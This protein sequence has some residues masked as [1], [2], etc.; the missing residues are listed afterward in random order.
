MV[1]LF[2]I[3]KEVAHIS[4][5]CY[6]NYLLKDI[7]DKYGKTIAVKIF[8][9]FHFMCDL[10]S[11]NPYS[12]ISESE[13]LEFIIRNICPELPLEV[14][15]D[16]EMITEALDS[17]RKIY[18]T[19]SYRAYLATKSLIDKY[20]DKINAVEISLEKDDGNS[21]EVK[22]AIEILESIKQIAKKQF[23]DLEEENGKQ[24]A[25]GGGEFSYDD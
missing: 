18:E 9:V 4:E 22:K 16:D 13:K 12:N 11:D 5:Y 19:P 2:H 10:S 7:I 21:A 23:S 24:S 15:W 20:I 17:C 8:T 3:D 25:K 1:K 14:D 6:T